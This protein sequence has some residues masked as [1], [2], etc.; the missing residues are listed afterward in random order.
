MVSAQHQNAFI[1]WTSTI[2]QNQI[3]R[4]K[5]WMIWNCYTKWVFSLLFPHKKVID[6]SIWKN[7]NWDSENRVVILEMLLKLKKQSKID[8][9]SSFILWRS[10]N[11]KPV[12]PEFWYTRIIYY[13]KFE[14]KANQYR[15]RCLEKLPRLGQIS[16][17]FS[18]ETRD[19]LR[20]TFKTRK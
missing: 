18:R 4:F 6:E 3:F 16:P 9:L 19:S 7:S 15:G 14:R 8:Y 1:L 13:Y 5:E 10:N 17:R 11:T 12:F 20:S 2:A